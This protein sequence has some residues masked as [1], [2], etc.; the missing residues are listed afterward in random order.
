MLDSVIGDREV[1]HG[2][3]EVQPTIN[4]CSVGLVDWKRKKRTGNTGGFLVELGPKAELSWLVEM[5]LR[6]QAPALS[7]VFFI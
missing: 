2:V 5:D 1:G 3:E 7:K 4:V 6:R